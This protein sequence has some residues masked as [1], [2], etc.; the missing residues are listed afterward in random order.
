VQSDYQLELA[1]AKMQLELQAFQ[2]NKEQ[3]TAIAI[4]NIE[5]AAKI[6]VARVTAKIAQGTA[7]VQAEMAAAQE[8]ADAA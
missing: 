4:A 7:M 8:P 3:E 1:K 6:E 5:A 2:H